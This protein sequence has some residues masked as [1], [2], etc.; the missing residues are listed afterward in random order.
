MME[1]ALGEENPE[2]HLVTLGQVERYF[3]LNTNWNKELKHKLIL[4]HGSL[5]NEGK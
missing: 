2:L 4:E 1:E 3:H 5:F